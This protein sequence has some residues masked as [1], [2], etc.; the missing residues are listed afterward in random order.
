MCIAG[1]LYS[2]SPKSVLSLLLKQQN[3][4]AP[5]DAG[6]FFLYNKQLKSQSVYVI[7]RFMDKKVR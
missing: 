3:R 6:D 7:V 2:T 4:T 1:R 5:T